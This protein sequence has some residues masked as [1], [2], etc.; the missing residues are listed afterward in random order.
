MCWAVGCGIATDPEGFAGCVDGLAVERAAWER[1]SDF[2]DLDLGGSVAEEGDA[3]GE[4]LEEGHHL[5]W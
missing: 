3:K 5:E 1:G 4:G 2:E